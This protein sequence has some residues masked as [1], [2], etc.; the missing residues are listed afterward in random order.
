MTN[1]I[2]A[3]IITGLALVAGLLALPVLLRP[4]PGDYSMSA[5]RTVPGVAS[6][7]DTRIPSYAP[8]YSLPERASLV[9][10]IG[11]MAPAPGEP[12]TDYSSPFAPFRPAY[13]LPVA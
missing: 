4:R 2:A 8:G 3:L 6:M 1:H 5:A 10:C 12:A 13:M 11:G 9:V 7:W